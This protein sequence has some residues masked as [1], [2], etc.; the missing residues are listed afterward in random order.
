MLQLENSRVRIIASEDG[1]SIVLTDLPQRM[2]W[3]VDTSSMT[4]RRHGQGDAA[5]PPVPGSHIPTPAETLGAG[6]ATQRDGAIEFAYAL[7][8]GDIRITWTLAHDHVTLALRCENDNVEFVALPGAIMPVAGSHELLLPI[9]QGVLLR[10]TDEPWEHTCEPAGHLGFSMHMAAAVGEAGALLITQESAT[11]WAG[12]FGQGAK[13][14]FVVFE[15]R[16]CPIDGWYERSVRLYPVKHDITA[17]CKR[18]RQ[19]VIERG[20]F[21]GWDEKIAAKPIVENLFGALM[22]FVGYNKTDQIDYVESARKLKAYGFDSILYY[23]TRLCHY[24]LDFK[25]GGDD[26]I[27]LS[28][29]EIKQMRQIPGTLLS[30]WAW[31]YEA[32]DD[33]SAERL[34]MFRHDAQGKPR[35]HWQIDDYRWYE[36]CTPYQIEFIKRRLATDMQAM[37][38]IHYDVNAMRP[39]LP[40]FSTDHAT[41][42]HTPM[43]RRRDMDFIR[44]LLSPATNGN[45]IV[46]SEGFVDHYAGAYDIGST[47]ILP[48][49][50]D[51]PCIPVPMTMLV[52]HD[53]CIHDW[54]EVHNYNEH[55]GFAKEEPS[56]VGV[57]CC[58]RPETK[59][60][61]DA[62]YGCPP[63][64][65]P[66][67]KQ[68]AWAD[69]ATRRT[70]SYIVKL[71]DP[72]VQQAIRAA[73]PVA[74][75][76]KR[77]GRQELLS[78]KPVTNDYAVQS[79]T[80]ADGTRIVANLS[81]QDR[82][83]DDFGPVPAQTWRELR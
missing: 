49:W 76:H 33:G 6:Q 37:D 40:C 51:T 55:P 25:M 14:P 17:I 30:P 12:T 77:I 11:D 47:K 74:K 7:P 41:H 60:A 54:W 56:R 29:E 28:D 71:D 58:G 52:F 48:A 82:Q 36:V 64:L 46:S 16:R 10:G 81:D 69:I 79:T 35:I 62:L 22:A 53:S 75:L 78:F 27:W 61:M 83:T 34:A 8:D 2:S 59:A 57:N 68:Y 24:S 72:Q 3:M 43:G 19:R 32:L 63:N 80:F 38:W 73:L 42:N 4:F 44:E 18:Y 21:V 67:G 13:G 5:C 15:Q 45:R 23:S 26:P 39:G 1:R 20:D 31:V 65:F 70:Y 50:G 66:F 9:Y